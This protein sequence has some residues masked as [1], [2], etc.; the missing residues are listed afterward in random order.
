LTPI[1]RNIFGPTTGMTLYCTVLT[2]LD[3]R[4]TPDYIQKQRTVLSTFETFSVNLSLAV[5]SL[6]LT[7]G[8]E[9]MH[10]SLGLH[11]TPNMALSNHDA[12]F[13]EQPRRLS[14][15]DAM[16]APKSSHAFTP[17]LPPLL[18]QDWD[19]GWDENTFTLQDLY[20][21]FEQASTSVVKTVATESTPPQVFEELN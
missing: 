10:P 16:I 8:Y 12:W 9:C 7:V 3:C 4:Q 15:L 18:E 11:S 20:A 6:R 14:S 5:L 17:R 19:L 2:G 21:G 13:P 1:I